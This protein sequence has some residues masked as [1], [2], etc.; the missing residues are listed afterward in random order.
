MVGIF[1]YT[2][3]ILK[4]G[5]DKNEKDSTFISGQAKKKKEEKLKYTESRKPL[6]FIQ[7]KY[8]T[9]KPILFQM[10][11]IVKDLLGKWKGW[12]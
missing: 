11:M 12:I 5:L 1:L 10:A 8:N 7:R 9:K 6:Y 3:K 2:C 4:K